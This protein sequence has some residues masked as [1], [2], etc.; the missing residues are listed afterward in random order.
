[1]K[2]KVDEAFETN[3]PNPP[4]P[5]P[6]PSLHDLSIVERDWYGSRNMKVV[7]VNCIVALVSE[8]VSEW[9]HL[10]DLCSNIDDSLAQL[11]KWSHLLC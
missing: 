3:Q 11:V 4:P 9:A 2:N 8:W 6:H 7:F 10:F 1:M 5:P